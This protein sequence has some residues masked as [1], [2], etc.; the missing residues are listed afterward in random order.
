MPS[1][2]RTEQA[3][4]DLEEIL[5]YLEER[6]PAAAERVAEAIDRRCALLEQCPEMGRL[7]E[8]L[9][10]GIRSLAVE[11]YGVFYRVTPSAVEILRILHG[12]RDVERILRPDYEA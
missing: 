5:E 11:G 12:S 3:E 1:V 8:E 9:G 10:P 4:T 6:S 2:L 7:R